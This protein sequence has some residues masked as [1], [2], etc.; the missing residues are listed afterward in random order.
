MQINL[1][2]LFNG[3]HS[4]PTI[5]CLAKSNIKRLTNE[6]DEDN[7]RLFLYRIFEL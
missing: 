4:A 3:R 7:P 5:Q 2:F 6:I 1:I